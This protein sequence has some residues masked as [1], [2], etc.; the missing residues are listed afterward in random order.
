MRSL[1]LPLIGAL[2]VGT[3]APVSA[4]AAIPY[5]A[6]S[7]KSVTASADDGNSPRNTLDHNLGTRWSANGDGQSITFDLSGTHTIGLVRFAFYAGDQRAAV[8][9]VQTSVDG[10]SWTTVRS[11]RGSGTGLGLETFDFTDV[12][13]R[14][15]RY[16][17]HGNS[18]NAWN[19]IT[20]AEI[21]VAA[22]QSQRLYV[23]A[24]GRLVTPAYSNGDRIADF[25]TVG[26]RGGGVALPA[27]ATQRTVQPPASGD[28]GASIQSAIDAVSALPLDSNGFRGAVQLV[29]GVYPVS[30]TLTIRASGVVLRGAGQSTVIKATGT[31]PRTLITFA[32]SGA[33]SEVSGTR[34]SISDSYVPVGAKSLTVADASGF[35]VGDE[36]VVT[37]T[38]NQEWIDS[39]GMDACTGKGTAYDTADVSGSTCLE[40]PWTPSSRTM[41]YE[42]R[43]TAIDGNRLT[44]DGPMVEAFQ[45]QFGGGA[46]YKY[47]FAGRIR[48]VGVEYLR[49]ESSF[50]S[51]TDEA[52]AER[53][54]AFSAVRDGWAREITSAYFVQGTVVFTRGTRNVTVQDSASVDHK[55]QITGGRR[56]PF[57]I[58]GAS[59]ILV[60][61][62]YSSTGRHDFVTGGNTP[63]PNVFLDSRASNS[64]SELGPHHRWGVGTLF[65]NVVHQSRSGTQSMAAYNRGNSGTGHGWS[66]AY[67][68]Y[69]NCVGDSMII[70]SPPGAR[71]WAIG[72]RAGRRSGT[73]EYESFGGPVGPRSLYLQQLRD[74]LGLGALSNIGY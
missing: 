6:A 68:V 65:D 54:V 42:R 60:M 66:G 41:H 71:N 48:N 64:E 27:V 72:C 31:T 9:D 7:V 51:A 43:I 29:A 57:D 23:G 22:A 5:V 21:H 40:G 74:R 11:G 52:H 26:Y 59:H 44:F 56:Y 61:R 37:R 47:T 62:V 69:Y 30:G 36:V 19:S 20:E 2:V 14:Y 45:S 15:V 34:K 8:F 39:V 53:M 63:G 13:A 18:V 17:G 49:A 67:Q 28:A 73:G 58:E 3:L 10:S 33:I 24:D 35:R 46:V 12:S 50:T 32:G 55:S 16:L 70:S 1:T 25:S 38:P 4:E